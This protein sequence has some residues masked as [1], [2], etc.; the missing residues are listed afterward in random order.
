MKIYKIKDK[1]GKATYYYVAKLKKE[2]AEKMLKISDIWK[3]VY[4]FDEYVKGERV[5]YAR[6]E[7]KK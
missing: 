6:L 1:R 7:P 4:I 2:E 3:L 5:T